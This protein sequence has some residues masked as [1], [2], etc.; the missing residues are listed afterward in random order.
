MRE[1]NVNKFG[2]ITTNDATV[3]LLN[4]YKEA[5]HSEL[6]IFFLLIGNYY[7]A[8]SKQEVK[9]ILIDIYH[10]PNNKEALKLI[11]YLKTHEADRLFDLAFYENYFGQMAYSRTLDNFVTYFKDILS[12]VVLKKP[13][14]LKSSDQE[15]LDFILTH[16]NMDDLLKSLSE[17]K[18]EALFYKGI[19]D[20]EKYFKSRL[21]I[22]IFKDNETKKVINKLVK[23]R[24]LIVHNR[25]RITK[26][27]INE[28]PETGFKLDDVLVFKYS[29][30]STLN[31]H[32]SNFLVELDIEIAEKYNLELK[33][34]A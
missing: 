9:E 29:E 34:G 33:N 8:G 5:Q 1:K 19:N 2:A 21:N 24:N 13:Q 14:I 16:T 11:E 32:L 28:F 23:Q 4:Y 31:L 3:S 15:S 7:I 12:E 26:E 6:L 10:D 30:I 17:K 20:I 27:F 22:D 25:G 18:I